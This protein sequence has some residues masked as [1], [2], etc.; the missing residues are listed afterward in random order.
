MEEIVEE[1]F[2]RSFEDVVTE[3]MFERDY[4]FPRTKVEDYIMS[5]VLTPYQ[6]FN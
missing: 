3:A 2:E 6:Q 1:F 5:I 4:V